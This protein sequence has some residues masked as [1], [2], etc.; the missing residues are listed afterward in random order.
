MN[1]LSKFNH[2]EI[3]QAD[4]YLDETYERENASPNI[5][6]A[7]LRRWYIVLITFIVLCGGGIP[8]L[9]LVIKPVYTTTGTIEVTPVLT[10]PLTGQADKGEISNYDFFMN[11]QAKLMTSNKVL[12]RVADILAEKDLNFFRVPESDHLTELKNVI[13]NRD[14]TPDPITIIKGAIADNII[15]IEHIRHTQLLGISMTSRNPQEA[16]QIVNAFIDA[17]MAV[18]E[19]SSSEGE[20][21]RL[22]LLENQR[23]LLLD[24][25]ELQR[26]QIQDLAAQYGADSLTGLQEVTNDKIRNLHSK[27]SE[28]EGKR[29]HLQNQ[30]E[31]FSRPQNQTISSV[32]RIS[33]HN[34][35]VNSDPFVEQVTEQIA[36]RQQELIEA[37][38][39]LSETNPELERKRNL[40]KSLE[41]K[42][43]QR[44][45]EIG[46]KFDET[47]EDEIKENNE[48]Q[49]AQT[50]LELERAENLL[51]TYNS[52]LKAKEEETVQLGKLQWEIQKLQEQMDFNKDQLDN[53]EQAIRDMRMKLELPP[54]ITVADRAN[55]GSPHSKRNKLILALIFGALAAGALL[56]F[57]RDKADQSLH[58]PEDVV[59]CIGLP[60]LGTTTSLEQWDTEVLSEY[61]SNDY[62]T[63]RAN[64]GLLSDGKIPKILAVTSPGM[65]EGKTTLSINLAMSLAK[66]GCRVLLIDGDL[67]K[68]DIAR[69][70]NLPNHSWGLQDVLLGLRRFEETA[71]TLPLTGL[72]VLTSDYRNSSA[73]IEQLSQPQTEDCIRTIGQSYDHVIIDTPPILAAPDSLFWAKIADAVVLSTLAGQTSGPDL[74]EALERLNRIKVRI[75]GN[76]LSNVSTKHSYHRYGYGYYGGNGKEKGKGKQ[77]GAR[78]LLVSMNAQNNKEENS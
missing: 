22:T 28:L 39:N 14:T 65:G 20:N 31:M 56:A 60:V 40:I 37:M 75:L 72:D 26:S 69:M 76:V 9:W 57:L 34:E 36:L 38:Q 63:I 1:E 73:A 50:K 30:L 55:S 59:K 12:H 23:K 58:T 61:I 25:I 16:E 74:K 52:Q 45:K 32:E 71:R 46:E 47:I 53:Y 27:I 13:T 43:E 77:S 54:R 62:Q 18:V 11:T 24:K 10:N 67:R 42:L 68:P 49:L 51:E 17:Y 4:P 3:Q 6:S 48:S 66:I 8:V 7:I 70:L 64:L 44:K 21:R 5:L 2:S 15:T 41:E 78:P 19:I 33:L 29:M 35:A